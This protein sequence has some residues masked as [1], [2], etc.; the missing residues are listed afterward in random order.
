MTRINQIDFGP[1]AVM[2]EAGVYY[3]L[4]DFQNLVEASR[5]GIA[6]NPNEWVEHH[7]LGIGYE[8][9]G[10]LPEAISEYQKAVELSNGDQ[11]AEASL[12][13]AY[14]AIGKRAEA[15]KIQRDF[16]RKSKDGYVS[17]YIVA[18]IYAGLGEKDRAF[19]FLEKSY[20]ERS[21][22]IS[23]HLKADLRIDNLRSD[24][25]FQDLVRRVGLPQ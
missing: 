18:T 11:D 8:G 7:Y 23:W 24:P 14:A 15:E 2:T 5:R 13:N 1:S 6:S 20:D 3:Q 21:P 10:K 16:E 19:Q 17:P 12:A 22:D 25:R 9:I 4:R